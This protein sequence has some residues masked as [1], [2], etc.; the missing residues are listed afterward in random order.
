MVSLFYRQ[1]GRRHKY[2]ASPPMSCQSSGARERL[3]ASSESYIDILRPYAIGV[4]HCIAPHPD[5]SVL[6]SGLCILS[7]HCSCQLHYFGIRVIKFPPASPSFH[8]HSHA[9]TFT[10]IG[11]YL[12]PITDYYYSPITTRL[13]AKC[14]FPPRLIRHASG[15]PPPAHTHVMSCCL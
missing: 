5:W 11:D 9:I 14:R 7:L 15:P 10:I 4:H 3:L 8:F 1:P 13:I 12:R 2:S 6:A